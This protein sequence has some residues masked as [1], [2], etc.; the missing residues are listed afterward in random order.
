[1]LVASIMVFTL[2]ACGSNE[3]KVTTNSEEVVQSTEN[4]TNVITDT[5]WISLYNGNV[6]TLNNDG[7]LEFG[8][9][10]G[11][12][13]QDGDTLTLKYKVST[14]GDDLELYADILEENG[15]AIIRTQKSGKVNGSSSNFSIST[16][17]PEK[18]IA[19]IKAE[20]ANTVGETV[21]TDIMEVTVKKAALGYYANGASTSTSTGITANVNEACEPSESG[22]YESSKGR[23]LLCI[24]FVIKN[25][26]RGNI[27]TSDYIINFHVNQNGKSAIVRGYDL[28]SKDGTYGLN[29]S[30]MPI[31]IDGGDFKTNDTDNKIIDAGQ[32]MEIKYVGVVGFEPD[33]LS[34]PF[35]VVV[36]MKNSNGES[37]KYIYTIE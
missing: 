14:S 10:K 22:F 27:N 12:W 21:S 30:R 26:D 31:S 19:E 35:E 23:C 28:N 24:D 2:V 8:E 13:E 36:D 15:I 25:T 32:S 11:T 16:Y 17:Y 33:D 7:S 6:M 34:A 5:K 9:N 29:L 18:N 3:A 1:M 20:I 4:E 37:E